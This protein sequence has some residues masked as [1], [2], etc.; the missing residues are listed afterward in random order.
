MKRHRYLFLAIGFLILSGISALF[1]T[2]T[3]SSDFTLFMGFGLLPVSLALTIGFLAAWLFEIFKKSGKKP[4]LMVS[5]ILVTASA[6]IIAGIAT[7]DVLFSNESFFP[8]LFGLILFIFALP[9]LAVAAITL[10][11]IMI[12]KKTRNAK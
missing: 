7:W 3:F 6:L 4:G 1:F 2:E 11:V 12:V 8:G 5:F 10:L 9:P